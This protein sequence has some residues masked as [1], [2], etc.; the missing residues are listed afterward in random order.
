MTLEDVLQIYQAEKPEG[1][2]VQFG[3]QTPLN[4]AAELEAAGCRILGTSV[5]SIDA[6]EDRD[7]FHSIMDRLGIPMPESRMASDLDGALKVVAEIGYPIVIRPSFVLGGR[8]ME[9]IYDEI[10]LREYVDKAVGVTPDRPLYLDRF[11]CHAME[12]E[13]DALSD[14][15]DI[16]IPAIMQHIELAGI[17]SGDSAC[18]LP[19]VSISE[20]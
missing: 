1:I 18:V 7:L 8:G 10:M 20:E 4:I 17:H 3:G 19:P 14:G 15:R 11:L 6:A 16:F 13:A 9:V 12:C 2:I 5:K